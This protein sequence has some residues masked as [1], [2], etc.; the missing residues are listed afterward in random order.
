[1][2]SS[3]GIYRSHVTWQQWVI[4]RLLLGWGYRSRHSTLNIYLLNTL[5]IT[6]HKINDWSQKDCVEPTEQWIRDKGCKQRD[7]IGYASPSVDILS[8]CGDRLVKFIC[9]V[10]DEVCSQAKE[11]KSLCYFNNCK[12]KRKCKL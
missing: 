2:G 12:Q 11:S 4:P 6:Y 10:C 5:H 1:M 8:R 3:V 9:E 7:Y